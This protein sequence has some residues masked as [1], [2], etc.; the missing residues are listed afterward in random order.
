MFNIILA[1]KLE[2]CRVNSKVIVQISILILVGV[3]LVI[4]VCG[5]DKKEGNHG[6]DRDY[7]TPD[8]IV[9]VLSGQT[10]KS[11]FDITRAEHDVDFVQAPTGIFIKGIDSLASNGNRAWLYS[12]NDSFVPIAADDYITHDT[13]IIKWHYRNF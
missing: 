12:V 8:S 4:S 9:I 3:I 1:S 5:G 13:D 10:G 6:K 7:A 11:V 2:E